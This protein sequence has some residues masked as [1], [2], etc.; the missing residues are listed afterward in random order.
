[1]RRRPWLG[2]DVDVAE[3]MQLDRAGLIGLYLKFVMIQTNAVIVE[4]TSKSNVKRVECVTYWIAHWALTQT[5]KKLLSPWY[6]Q[7]N[8]SFAMPSL[9]IRKSLM[10]CDFAM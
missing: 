3:T 1:M 2:N 9:F 7:H 5:T 10:S 6:R 4:L 8:P